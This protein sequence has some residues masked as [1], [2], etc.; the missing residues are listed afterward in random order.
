V[1]ATH[2]YARDVTEELHGGLV[3]GRD[4]VRLR[5]A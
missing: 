3:L 2:P 4:D 1:P 5:D